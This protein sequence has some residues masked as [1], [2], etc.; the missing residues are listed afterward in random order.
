VNEAQFRL[1][2]SLD[3]GETW[4]PVDLEFYG[5]PVAVEV[6]SRNVVYILCSD[7]LLKYTP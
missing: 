3:E 1:S 7:K 6:P 2:K 5:L 4:S